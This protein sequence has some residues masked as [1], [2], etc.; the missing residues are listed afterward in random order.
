MVSRIGF[1]SS[2]TRIASGLLSSIFFYPEFLDAQ[3]KPPIGIK[4]FH[5]FQKLEPKI[6]KDIITK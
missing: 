6:K 2:T 1:S 4:S 5:F 3:I